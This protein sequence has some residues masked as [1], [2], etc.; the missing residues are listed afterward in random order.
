M[1]NIVEYLQQNQHRS[2]TRR[3]YYSVWK[4]FN[5][6]FVAL[7]RKPED[8]EHRLLLFAAY[9][10]NQGKQSTT[11]KSYISA[12]KAVLRNINVK[13]NE[14]TCLLN[15]LTRACRL[16]N[17]TTVRL[18]LPINR[19][20]LNIILRKTDTYFSEAGQFYLKHLY[21]ALMSTMYYGLFRIGELTKSEHTVKAIDVQI[22]TN[23]RKLMFILRSSKNSGNDK[24]PQIIKIESTNLNSNNIY[25]PY[26][27]L[28]NYMAVRSTLKSKEENFFVFKDRSNVT[29]YAFMT[30]FKNMIKL[31]GFNQQHYGSHSLRSGRSQDLLKLGFSVETI[32]KLGRWKSNAVFTYLK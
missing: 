13:I 16:L 1:K 29:S 23:K 10:I 28:R 22:G 26:Q 11:V 19:E 9:L 21:L 6:F 12:I 7:D 5:K 27:L 32:K 15:S 4:S 3:N 20:M 14:N 25:C 31:A 2:T 18:R 8:W 17:D 30:V 24:K